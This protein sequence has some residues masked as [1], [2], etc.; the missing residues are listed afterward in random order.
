MDLSEITTHWIVW[1]ESLSLDELHRER[2][3][4]QR[5]LDNAVHSRGRK[6]A[7]KRVLAIDQEIESREASK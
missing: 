4:W 3:Y 6:A 5:G 1:I 2:D 7:E